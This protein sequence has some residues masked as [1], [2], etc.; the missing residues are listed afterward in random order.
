M[1]PGVAR[2][3]DAPASRALSLQA[4]NCAASWE[5]RSEDVPAGTL[6]PCG[7]LLTE[8][9]A[10]TVSVRP[11]AHRGQARAQPGLV[12]EVRQCWAC[13]RWNEILLYPAA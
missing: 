11:I 9:F 1:P 12:V 5:V 7:K 6:R 8:V 3:G 4:V 2:P 13:H 10:R